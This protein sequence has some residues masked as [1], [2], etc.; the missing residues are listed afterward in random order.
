M[1]LLD[2]YKESEQYYIEGNCDVFTG[3]LTTLAVE[4]AAGG[5]HRPRKV[6][7]PGSAAGPSHA[8]WKIRH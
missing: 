5:T 4:D 6:R 8:I 3:D 1:V 7:V 2:S